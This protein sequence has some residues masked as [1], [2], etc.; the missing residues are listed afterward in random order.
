MKKNLTF[1]LFVIA[2]LFTT[3]AF[4]QNPPPPASSTSTS[5]SSAASSSAA[6]TIKTDA[7]TF[8][9][10]ARMGGDFLGLTTTP[11]TPSIGFFVIPNLELVA[12]LTYVSN[13]YDPEN[14]GDVDDSTLGFGVGVNYYIPFKGSLS[15]VVGASLNYWNDED[16]GGNED[17]LLGLALNGGI[18]YGIT[19]NFA[20]EGGVSLIYTRVTNDQNDDVYSSMRFQFGYIGFKGFF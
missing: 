9:V 19:S 6:G 17:T 8:T 7:G 16:N 3:T 12:N 14:G 10:G 1:I 4:A 13:T 11:L 15:F 20:L 18:M 5:S 2:T